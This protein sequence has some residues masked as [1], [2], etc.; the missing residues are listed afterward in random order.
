MSSGISKTLSQNIEI[1]SNVE[2]S[3]DI[4]L[5]NTFTINEKPFTVLENGIDVT[6][7]ANTSYV[8]YD[9]D[10]KEVTEINTAEAGTYT[11]VYTV[12]YD[13]KQEEAETIVNVLG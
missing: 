7:E 4:T 2:S 9:G 8:I 5:G 12:S 6:A 3:I 13:G 10:G 11:V 1:T